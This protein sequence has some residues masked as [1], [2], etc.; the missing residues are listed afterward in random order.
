M[1]GESFKCVLV[2]PLAG[3]ARRLARHRPPHVSSTLTH[4]RGALG[5][6]LPAAR[7]RQQGGLVGLPLP[8]RRTAVQGAQFGHRRNVLLA[9]QSLTTVR[10]LL[11]WGQRRP[12]TILSCQETFPFQVE[13]EPRWC[14]AARPHVYAPCTSFGGREAI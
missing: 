3:R 1:R 8:P 6:N 4:V 12:R 13:P 9:T 2:V 14:P 11:G 7:E 5:L 10:G